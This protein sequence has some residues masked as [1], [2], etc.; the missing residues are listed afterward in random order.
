MKRRKDMTPEERKNRAIVI[1]VA[2]GIFFLVLVILMFTGKDDNNKQNTNK[3]N[4]NLYPISKRFDN[5]ISDD[6]YKYEF[7][8]NNVLTIKGEKVEYEQIGVKTYNNIET[9]Y[10]IKRRNYYLNTTGTYEKVKDL[11]L[12]ETFDD[13]FID[14]SQ[15]SKILR[16]SDKLDSEENADEYI[17]YFEISVSELLEYYNEINNTKFKDET[18][19]YV[20]GSFAYDG[21]QIEITFN[22]TNL[23]TIINPN[24]SAEMIYTLKYYDKNK[25]KINVE[26][27]ENNE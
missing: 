12:F 11:N 14:T 21:K 5:F 8:I 6:N 17:Q 10:Y 1:L 16:N 7:N 24:I 27:G 23:Y 18:N 20:E 3:L 22:F 13:T 9:S 4:D 19:S 15:I 26:L 25:A 2:Y